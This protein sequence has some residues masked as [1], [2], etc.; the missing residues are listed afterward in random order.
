M[1]QPELKCPTCGYDLHGLEA[2]RDGIFRCPEC[3]GLTDIMA[4]VDE[5]ARRMREQR[6]MIGVAIAMISIFGTLMFVPAIVPGR[7]GLHL[8]AFALLRF[9]AYLTV[10]LLLTWRF[11]AIPLPAKLIVAGISAGL[12]TLAQCANSEVAACTFIPMLI[13]WLIGFNFWVVNRDLY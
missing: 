7:A 6:R 9:A 4:I 10:W 11:Y 1:E 8:D 5:H 13:F 2:D 12:M 3:G